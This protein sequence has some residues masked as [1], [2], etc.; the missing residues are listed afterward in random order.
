MEVKKCLDNDNEVC[1]SCLKSATITY[2]M[3]PH[4]IFIEVDLMGFYGNENCT[5]SSIPETIIIN[6]NT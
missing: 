6:E 5:V 4:I 2:T 1:K 3:E